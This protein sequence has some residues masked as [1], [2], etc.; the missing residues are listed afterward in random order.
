MSEND[1]AS[2]VHSPSP[3]TGNN[4]LS[5]KSKELPSHLVQLPDSPWAVWRWIGLRSAG[6]PI[7]YLA[8]LA[9]SQCV[10]AANRYLVACDR[11]QLAQNQALAAL[12]KLQSSAEPNQQPI[13]QK[14]IRKVQKGKVP[15][16]LEILAARK[17][18]DTFKEVMAQAEAATTDFQAT[19]R[20][21]I[22]QAIQAIYAVAQDKKFREALLWQN[23]HALR[24]G[25][26]VLLR[27]PPDVD[28]R[29]SQRRQH[30]ALV[31]NYL[32]RYCA[33]NDTIGFFGPST[34][35]SV[36]DQREVV[37][38]QPGP[39]L[40]AARNVY[41][42]GWGIDTLAEVLAQDEALYPWFVPRRMPQVDV[43]EG[44]FHLPLTPPIRTSAAQV[45]VFQACDGER[46]AQEIAQ[47][48]LKYP[49]YGFK[50]TAEVYQVLK[51]LRDRR[52]IAW[53]LEVPAEGQ[54][55]EEHLRKNLL[56][57][58]DESRCQAA[59]HRLEELETARRAV[60]EAAGNVEQ[61]DL[62]LQNLETTFTRLTETAPTRRAGETYAARTLLYEDCRRDVKV[63]FGTDFIAALTPPL[64]LLLTSARWF[65]FQAAGVFRNALRGI[66]TEL[67]RKTGQTV[68][69]FAS[70]W[71]WAHAL[72]LGDDDSPCVILA[73]EFQARWAAILAIPEGQSRVEYASKDL[74][75]S[76]LE[77]F[78]APQA[79]WPAA[80]YHSPDIMIAASSL[81]AMQAGQYQCIL[82][83][84]HPGTNTLWAGVFVGR[85]PAPEK[86]SQF[87]ESD[88]REPRLVL[89][90]SRERGGPTARLSN[91]LVSSQDW[92]LVFAHDTC[93]VPAERALTIGSL[94]LEETAA[95]LIVRTRDGRIRFEI[96]DVLKE[97]I[98]NKIIHRFEVVPSSKHRPRVSFDRLVISREAWRFNSSEIPYVEEK[99][100]ADRFAQV[101][102]WLSIQGIPR[103]VFVKTP[104]ERK[105]FYVDF[106]SPIS[107]NLFAKAVRKV[108][109]SDLPEA[110]ITVTEMLP[111]PEQT[112]L[113]DR[114]GRHYASE[115][116]IVAVD[117]Q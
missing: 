77:T 21:T 114:E 92:R 106:A 73:Q 61:L 53:T 63:A 102:H 11:L 94:V 13:L 108:T 113:V 47:D 55:P 112:W 2:I 29:P 12:Q 14:A 30:E 19:F 56:R 80:C 99:S 31:V 1:R 98:L 50:N 9:N 107:V 100:E 97:L 67:V 24:T 33:K 91:A 49:E 88:L 34:W 60:A 46:T 66:Y 64:T 15:Q 70:F 38:V 54:H 117:L 41:F 84:L 116:R 35:A 76:V 81:E 109:E 115:L 110:T 87:R 71:L 82:G 3:L 20:A 62:A 68:V 93:G 101:Q 69:D 17:L 103:F 89:V 65:T 25:V 28:A 10:K 26:D 58:G 39:T 42:E 32:Q 105:P 16:G 22:Q 7:Q 79:G 57:I 44:F 51:E 36:S 83:E 4:A 40:L 5:D 95:G 85:H 45:A 72:I 111:T 96:I 52:R 59:L 27:T 8:G 74:R 104:L 37:T 18:L 78:A 75:Q 23:R 90:G 48:L 86:L 6:F 43:V